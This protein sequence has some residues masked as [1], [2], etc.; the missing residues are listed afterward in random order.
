MGELRCRLCRAPGDRRRWL[1]RRGDEALALV[2][3]RGCGT[4]F[5]EPQPS[6]GWLAEE[7]RNYFERRATALVRPK[8]DHFR[9][10]L[11][12]AG[13]DFRG[14]RVVELGPGEGDCIAALRAGWS[15]VRVTAVEAN[16]QGRA[17]LEALGCEVVTAPI[18]RWVGDGDDRFDA[19][20]LFDLLEH[21]REPLAVAAALGS[22]RLE[23]GG[24]LIATFPNVESWSRRALG[25]W[26]PQYKVEH[27]F[28]FSRRAVAAL[29]GAAGVDTLRLERLDKRL[30]LAYLLQ[31][32]SHFGPPALRRASRLVR[33]CLPAS[34]ATLSP[35][36]PLGEW[37][38]VARRTGR[39]PPDRAPAVGR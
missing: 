39:R 18:E 10:L 17:H 9:R 15:G 36:L 14:R 20:L 13:I 7:Y 16:P 28:Y 31:V 37:L 12:R 6:D 24:A 19:V 2:R 38:W 35:P 4:E 8:R 23:A 22:R 26:W 30:P 33:P 3:C 27:L 34:L 25:R 5:L 1:E 29:A 21:L 11:A 32:G